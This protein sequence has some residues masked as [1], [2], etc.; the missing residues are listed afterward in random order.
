[1]WR[2]SDGH[3]P[4]TAAAHA[5]RFGR[6]S[7]ALGAASDIPEIDS[8]TSVA[9]PEIGFGLTPRELHVLR[10]VAAGRSNKVIAH[11]LCLSGKTIDRHLSKSLT[12]ETSPRAPPQPLGPTST[13]L[14]ECNAAVGEIP[15]SSDVRLGSLPEAA[16]G[17][18][19]YG[20]LRPQ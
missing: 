15:H 12:S 19:R 3:S 7:K 6:R 4:I 17:L 16:P 13:S 18:W 11:E 8:Q 1:M 2:D 10:L 20:L 9:S 5:L 14:S